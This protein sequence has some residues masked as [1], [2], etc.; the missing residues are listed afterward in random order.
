MSSIP[1]NEPL[2]IPPRV[3]SASEPLSES[4]ARQWALYCHLAAFAVYVIPAVGIM[5]VLGPFIVWNIKKDQSEFVNEQGKESINFQ[6]SMTI[7]SLLLAPLCLIGLPLIGITWLLSIV[8]PIIAGMAAQ[9][10]EHYR[11]PLTLRVIS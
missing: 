9:K 8:M 11:Y 10:G 1:P 7:Y 6:L 2:P 3:S 4:E 5:N